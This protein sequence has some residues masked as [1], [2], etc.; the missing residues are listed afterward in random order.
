MARMTYTFDKSTHTFEKST[1]AIPILTTS[2]HFFDTEAVSTG[3]KLKHYFKYLQANNLYI[4][5]VI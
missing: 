2:V 1:P 4:G 5:V 3:F